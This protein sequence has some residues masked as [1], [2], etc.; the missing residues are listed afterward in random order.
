MIWHCAVPCILRPLAI[1]AARI[2]YWLL[3]IGHWLLAIGYW[4]LAIGYWPLAIGYRTETLRRRKSVSA[5]VT[6]FA[7]R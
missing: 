4:L 5:T 3:A 1:A 7:E 2:G 6:G